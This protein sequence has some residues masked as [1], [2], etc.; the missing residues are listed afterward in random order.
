MNYSEY[1]EEVCSFAR[2]V[3][4][5]EAKAYGEVEDFDDFKSTVLGNLYSYTDAH[6][7]TIYSSHSV[8]VIQH[9]DANE[10]ASE[11]MEDTDLNE[12]FARSGV[13]G[14]IDQY[15]ANCFHIDV[16]CEINNMS[17]EDFNEIQD[18]PN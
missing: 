12:L 10:A 15:A 18:C 14:I 11:R 13:D 8:H 16:E 2:N 3:M 7:Y 6:E 4:S 17:E 9:S 5:E 1:W